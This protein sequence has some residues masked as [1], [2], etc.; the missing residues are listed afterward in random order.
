MIPAKVKA[1]AILG[2]LIVALA[3]PAA[4]HASRDLALSQ[5]AS[6]NVVKAGGLVT[7]T[8][9]VSNQG[10][11]AFGDDEVFVN[12][13][14][15][16]GHG[17]SANNPYQSVSTSQGTCDTQSEGGSQQLVC[18]LGA[19]ASGASAQIVAVV[20][21][22]ES[23][24]NLA[25]LIPNRF[26][27]GYQDGNNDNNESIVRTT[28][29]TPPTLS[30]SKKIKLTGLP[31]GCATGD[32][33]LGAVAKVKGVKKMTAYLFM[34]FDRNGEGQ[35]WQ[36]VAKGNHLRAKVPASRLAPE[37]GVFYELKVSAKRRGATL[38]KVTVKF[39]PC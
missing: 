17:Q 37:L 22:N 18:T 24:N 5:V 28:A 12:V 39:Q 29:S 32:F 7:Y 31:A 8:V 27:G 19:L 30:G 26:E 9:T 14:S 4:A 23:A 34:G 35:S 21:V 11:E 6:A 10:T 33:T 13:F 36:K 16:R 38:Q 15:L 20:Q 2:A 1:G 3:L 25:A